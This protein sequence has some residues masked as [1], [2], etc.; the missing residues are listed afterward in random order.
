MTLEII[1]QLVREAPPFNAPQASSQVH[2]FQPFP[3][4]VLP[5][6]FRKLI[7]EGAHAIGC[8]PSFIALPLLAAAAAAIGNT[9]R[10]Q[11]KRGWT[12][13]AILWTAIVG[14]SGT[15]KSPAFE[16]ALQ[17]A[18]DRQREAQRG[19]TE[20]ISQYQTD[21][22]HYERDLSQWKKTSTQDGPPEQ[23]QRPIADRYWTDDATTEALARLLCSQERGILMARDELAG[24]LSGF[25]RYVSGKGGDAAR[26]LEMHGGRPWIIDRKTSEPIYV[27]AAAVSI[28]GGIQPETLRSCLG[29]KHLENGLAARL[30]MAYPPRKGKV[31]SDDDID[32]KLQRRVTEAFCRLYDLEPSRDNEGDPQP[33]FVTLDADAKAVWRAYYNTH[34][35]EQLDMPT[36]LSAAWSKLEGYAARLS[37]VIHFMRWASGVNVPKSKLILDELSINTGIT[38]SNWFGN[39]AHR[40]YAM[41]N[42]SVHDQHCRSLVDLITREGGSI[43]PRD[44]MRSSRQYPTAK[45]AEAALQELEQLGFGCMSWSTSSAKGGRPSHLFQLH[46]TADV[47]TTAASGHNSEGI[48]NSELETGP[49][50][51][52]SAGPIENGDTN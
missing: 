34:A 10:I 4:S 42:E 25:D 32:P 11:L 33:H 6:P 51:D 38:L 49:R 19:H 14:D 20:L 39:E 52:E 22:M 16:L 15:L 5:E 29:T 36:N 3:S 47:D 24:W 27:P 31:W 48:V 40:V 35:K 41:L 45:E 8:D 44:L 18:R 28:A 50:S 26:W 9:H 17:P 2:A 23:P 12:E 1:E 13:P 30:L 43:T 46:V 21:L 37:L 7:E